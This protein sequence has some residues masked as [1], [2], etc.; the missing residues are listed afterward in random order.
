MSTNLV[1]KLRIQ[2]IASGVTITLGILCQ[3]H[4]VIAAEIPQHEEP[5]TQKITQNTP[6]DTEE[7]EADIEIN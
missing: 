3:N 1:A 7:K 4:K 5:V 6:A 2:I